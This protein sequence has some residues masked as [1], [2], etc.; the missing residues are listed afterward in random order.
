MELRFAASPV[1]AK[2][3]RQGVAGLEASAATEFGDPR[4]DVLANPEGVVGE[5][6]K[7]KFSG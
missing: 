2:R 4:L 3:C 6:A 1:V 7:C 5:R